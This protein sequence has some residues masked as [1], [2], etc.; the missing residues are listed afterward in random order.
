MAQKVSTP[1]LSWLE[2]PTIFQV[3]RLDAHSDHPYYLDTASYEAGVQTLKQSLNGQWQVAW[4]KNPALRPADFW[5]EGYDL[6]AFRPIPVPSHLELNGYGQIQYTNTAYPWDGHAFLRPPQVDWEHDPV[7]SYVKE[8]DLDAPLLGKRVCI[9]FQGAEQAI[10]VWLN[11]QFIGYGEDSFTPSDFDITDAV[12]PRGNR[13]CVE[14]YKRSSAA[15]IEDQDFFRFSGL[16]REVFLYAKPQGHVEDLTVRA[17]YDPETGT[18]TLSFAA[19]VSGSQAATVSWNLLDGTNALAAGTLPASSCSSGPVSLEQIQPWDVG[20]PRLYRLLLQVLDDE[21]RVL[22]V[23]PW[24]VGF[25]RFEIQNN[26]MLLNGKRL[27]VNGV[28][29][30]EWHPRTGRAI[31]R[32]EM[33]EDIRIMRRNGINA[34]RT[35][36]YPNQSLWYTLCDRAGIC[37]MDE[38]NLESHG[39]CMKLGITETSW[40]IPGSD[41]AWLPCCLDRAKSM[42]Q[43]DKNHP[44]ILWWSAGNESHVGTVIQQMCDYFHAVDPTRLVHY[45]GVFYDRSYD[46]ITDIESRMYPTPEDVRAYLENDPPKPMCLCEYMHSMGNSVGGL[47]SYMRLREEFP[48]FQGG[49]LWDF[50]DQALYWSKDGEPERLLY[51]GDFGDRPSD[52]AF[53]ANGLLFADR[54][55]K[56]AMEEV[57]YWYLSE[58]ERAAFDHANA[59]RR[60]DC[61]RSA[62]RE[63][64]QFS[65]A[66]ASGPCL[67]VIHTDYNLGLYGVGF[68]YVFSFDKGGPVSLVVGGQEQLYRAPR[69]TFWRAPTEN[70]LGCNFPARSAA[71]MGADRYSVATACQVQEFGDGFT[72]TLDPLDFARRRPAREDIQEVEIRYT[73]PT[74]TTPETLVTVTYWVNAWGRI[75]V[76]LDY[77]GAQG[78]T[79]CRKYPLRVKGL[80]SLPAFGL[81]LLTARRLDSYRWDGLS[82]ETYPDRY[83][84]AQFGSHK[85]AVA[86]TPYLVPQE[87]GNHKD[88]YRLQAGELT[89]LC[90]ERP[91]HCSVLPYTQHQLAAAA[92]QDELPESSHTVIRILGALRGVGGI[93]SWRSDVEEPYR[94]SGEE[95]L[96]FSFY[97]VPSFGA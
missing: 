88:T 2:D 36:H 49:F 51:G 89:F 6:S 86:V 90:D 71:W 70:D 65:D 12:R 53:C 79:K 23:V 5:Q 56:P 59:R 42:Y 63:L 37:V 96:H 21:G 16:F 97:I 46:F 55:E 34:V 30:H 24:D 52:Y 32:Q 25:R 75:K 64:E 85:A 77:Q 18:G 68:H 83:K 39:T 72:E 13:L 94:V 69:P 14:L 8:F 82:G 87:C 7:A 3:N 1:S 50:I 91:F 40:N 95:E 35:S 10:Y 17:D 84:G 47:E 66:T 41:P 15:W 62:L 54:T 38:T 31:S 73:W 19:E 28:D 76:S 60:Q 67:Q 61:R 43:R 92:H 26:V 58:E 81:E 48:S 93:D 4:S 45:E 33:E 22:E 9:S 44:S 74:A 27:L 20:Q 11:G 29:R 57:R 80:R 78:G